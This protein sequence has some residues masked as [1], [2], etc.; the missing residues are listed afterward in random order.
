MTSDFSRRSKRPGPVVLL[1]ACAVWPLL[2]SVLLCGGLTA[3]DDLR[4]LEET[5]IRA[6]VEQ[7]A[8]SLVRI[9]TLGGVERLESGA[10]SSGP[11]TG[12]IIGAD[13]WIVSSAFNFIQQ[14]SSILITLPDGSRIPAAI[15]ARDQA[16]ALVLLKVDVQQPL[17]VPVPVERTALRVGQ[18]SIAVG[19]A[20]SPDEP[21]ISVGVIS[22]THRIWSRAIQTDA[23]ISP[24]NYGGALVDIQ[25]RV[26]GI[27]VPLS[28]QAQDE[29]AGAEWYDSGIGFA[30][31]LADIFARLE[32]WK[33]GHDLFPGLL[34]I[35]LKGNNDYTD[36]AEI[37][38]VRPNSPAAK[39][40]LKAGDTIIRVGDD[41]VVRLAHLK[42]ALGVR[43]AGDVVEVEVQ[44]GPETQV[45]SVE[46]IDKLVPYA[47]PFLG[48]LPRRDAAGRVVVRHVFAGSPA[49][50]ADLRPGDR[51]TS[52][53]GEAVSDLAS[54]WPLLARHQPGERIRV[55]VE[56]GE[57][58]LPVDL[59]L[60]ALPESS[61][62]ELPAARERTEPAADRP[63]VGKVEIKIPEE[64]EV[65]WAYVPESYDP[66]VEYGLLVWLHGNTRNDIDELIAQWR[67]LCDKHDLI[68]LAPTTQNDAGWRPTDLDYLR[69]TMEQVTNGY[70]IDS[71][72]IVVGGQQIG[73][74][75][76]YLL[77]LA[78]R[79]LVRGVV[80][81]DAAL[82]SRVRVPDN[83]PLRRL[84]FFTTVARGSRLVEAVE[85]GVTKLRE[86]R[87][88]VTV[89]EDQAAATDWNDAARSALARWIDSL[90]RL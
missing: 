81:V 4:T 29:I 36:P 74:A 35:A 64:P 57:A 22:A 31:P 2:W 48:V 1:A 5:A 12:M 72:R 70:R 49:A 34:G 84:A 58:T 18:W 14:P 23:K 10:V 33:Q 69:K 7:V 67:D 15:V 24:S 6:A 25:G 63:Q 46:L 80:A 13:G 78:Q 68:L 38:V 61:P 20:L 27:L 9:E 47:H 88:P 45:V 44:R 85:Q 90:D 83:E 30:I 17:A 40:G 60:S 28:P 54:I 89:W 77:A 79:D 55:T 82:P 19:R 41:R 42:H 59:E 53:H 66:Q 71:H 32:T 11:T 62:D 52:L 86:M 39:A 51:I 65:C 37:A 43:Y 87:F 16:R 56:R 3:Q 76:S 50:A 21:N 75:M 26:Q 8:D 73:G